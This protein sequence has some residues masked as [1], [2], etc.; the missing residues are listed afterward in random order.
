MER[1]TIPPDDFLASLTDDGVRADMTTL[2]SA[3]SE[4]MAGRERVLWT[5]KFWGGSDQRIIGYGSYTYKGRSGASGEWFVIGLAAQKNYLTVFVNAV[6]DGTYVTEAYAGK[7]GKAKVGKSTITFKR[8]ADI[9]LNALK[10]VLAKTRD[11]A[12]ASDAA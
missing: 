11:L 5:G 8:V 2:D 3:I 1:S 7:L 9:D 6:A 10:E 12:P 4:V